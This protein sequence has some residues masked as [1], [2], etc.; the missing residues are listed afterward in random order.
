MAIGTRLKEL[1]SEKKIT[2]RELAAISG[3]SENTLYGIIKRDNKTVKP[4]TAGK[5]ADALQI[6]INELISFD[7]FIQSTKIE[8]EDIENRQKLLDA[9]DQ[10]NNDGKIEAT[11]RVSELTEITRYQR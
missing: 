4:N 5:I 8:F 7:D 2:V 3:I 6:P 10:L 1:L 11:K 9:Y